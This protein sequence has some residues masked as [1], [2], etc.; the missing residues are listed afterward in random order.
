V[1]DEP[2][3]TPEIFDEE[4]TKAA[5]SD[6]LRSVFAE[7]LPDEIDPFSFIT[8]SGLED[9]VDWLA[10]SP[11]SLLIDLACGRGGPGLWLA[12]RTGAELVGVDFS[13]VG[14]DHA[15]LRAEELARGLAVKYLVADAASTGLPDNGAEGLVC[16]DAIQLMTHRLDVMREVR[17]VLKPGARAVFTTWEVPDRLA[18]LADLFE[19]GG[20]EP[21]VVEE[22]S[23]WLE[24]ERHIFER[25][26]MES[27]TNDDPGLKSLAEEADRVL[28]IM[29]VAR[30]VLGVAERPL[31]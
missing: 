15:Q 16:V 3:L 29:D 8:L 22:R 10:L 24:R 17:R 14:I 5:Q 23:D 20:L 7:D 13:T 21:V 27:A 31:R 18:D 28:P 12:R 1:T 30:R 2:Q 4:F 25:A 9:I 26:Q 11:G 19:E 6:W